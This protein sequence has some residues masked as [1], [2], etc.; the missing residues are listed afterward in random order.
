MNFNLFIALPFKNTVERVMI[1]PFLFYTVKLFRLI[2][3]L[4]FVKAAKGIRKLLF[5][6]L[7]SLPAL[8]NIAALLFIILFIYSCIG[9]NLFMN[10]KLQNS[11]TSTVNFQT[12][13]N[14]FLLLFRI[15][16]ISGWNDILE[17]LMLSSTDPGTGCD[18]YYDLQKMTSTVNPKTANGI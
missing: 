17:A 5:A 12:F 14:S 13:R 7:I 16:T 3:I 6:L 2:Q 4:R 18:N 9:M 15:G 1:N 10:V 11:L 8:V